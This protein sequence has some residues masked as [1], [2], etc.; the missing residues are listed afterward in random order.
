MSEKWGQ[1]LGYLV[2]GGALSGC[3][4]N[5]FGHAEP[6]VGSSACF[7]RVV[8]VGGCFEVA[9]VTRPILGVPVDPF[10]LIWVG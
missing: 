10:F 2:S 4:Q 7:D 1:H 5:G 6:R 3:R 8:P 9:F